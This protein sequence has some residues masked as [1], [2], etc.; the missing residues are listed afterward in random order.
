[1]RKKHAASMVHNMS[2]CGHET[3]YQ[4]YKNMKGRD[5]KHVNCQ[6]CLGLLK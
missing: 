3:T 2:M 4:E 1:M 6:R 5:L